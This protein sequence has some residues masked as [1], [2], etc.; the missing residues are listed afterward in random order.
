MFFSR[1][2]ESSP[3]RLATIK[4]PSQNEMF[5][6]EKVKCLSNASSVHFRDRS[7][8]NTGSY[9]VYQQ[10]V[11]LLGVSGSKGRKER[12]GLAQTYT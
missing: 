5:L 3:H 7:V 10:W 8:T 4:S 11:L 6:S 9:S 2:S 12:G 1:Q